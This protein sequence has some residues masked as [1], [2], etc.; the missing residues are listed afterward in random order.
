V[1]KI[2]LLLF[3]SCVHSASAKNEVV[4]TYDTLQHFPNY[5]TAGWKF[6]KADDSSM[7]KAGYNDSAWKTV[8]SEQLVNPTNAGSVEAIG[9]FRFHF[10][11]DKSVVNKPVAMTFTHYGASE[12]YLDGKLLKEFGH[13]GSRSTTVNFDPQEIPFIFQLADTG[14]HVIAVR[15]VNYNA[16]ENIRTFL[17]PLSGFDMML[18]NSDLFIAHR[19]LKSMLLST[20]MLLAGI[21]FTLCLLHLFMFLFYRSERTNIFFS[22]F[23]LC[24]GLGC[25]VYCIDYVTSNPQTELKAIYPVNALFCIGCVSLSGFVNELFQKKRTRFYIITGIAIVTMLLR[26]LGIRS[27]GFLTIGLIIGVSFE[28]V[29]TIIFGML[30]RRKGVWIIAL[31]FLLFTVF[32]LTI[33]FISIIH[34]GNL[35]VDDSTQGGRVI[36]AF[37]FFTIVSI[38]FSMSIFQAWR[39]SIINRDL[40]L[41]L[42][43]VK[44]LSEKTIEQ[45]K[46]KQLMLQNR[47]EELEEEVSLRTAELVAEKKKSDDLLLNILPAETAEELKSNGTSL[48]KNY[49][50]VTVMFTDF[51]NFTLA[52]ENMSAEALVGEINFCYS[53]FDTIISK[54]NLE[55]IKTIGD[56]YMCAGGLPVANIT[57]ATDTVKAAIEIQD[58]M[59]MEKAKR[60]SEGKPFFEIRIGIHT[61]PVVAGIVGIKKFAYDIWGD[62][63]NIASRM[64]S[65][66]ETGKINISGSTFEKIKNEFNCIHR[67]K[68]EAK[69]KGMID[70]YFVEGEL[71]KGL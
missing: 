68:I 50:L 28:A 40:K 3:I 33:M 63:V 4:L 35:T 59:N 45:E 32:V 19:D 20:F 56:S 51:K 65:K 55:K 27:F 24:L 5:F 12:I 11:A 13:V 25:V 8:S 61:G 23:M 47:K 2:F 71:S 54:F 10:H 31:G 1:R 57:N 69:N 26:F 17:E 67:G 41:Q 9:W 43:T 53:A 18:G 42:D 39:F 52:S 38:P 46:E 48:A 60:S 44:I 58:F 22:L 6:I 36:I 64:E 49:E 30:K 37:L 66:G 21:F 70:M 62:T 29:F 7:A 34:R 15:Y 16:S 14:Q